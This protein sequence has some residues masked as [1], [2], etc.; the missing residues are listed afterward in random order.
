MENADN[1]L[2]LS[3]MIIMIQNDPLYR[4]LESAKSWGADYLSG[5]TPY[6]FDKKTADRIIDDLAKL[7]CALSSKG[8][9]KPPIPTEAIYPALTII[10]REVNDIYENAVKKIG[11]SSR[12]I[13][14]EAKWK[15][16][17]LK[18]FDE[19]S[20]R[21]EAIQREYLDDDD[22]YKLNSGK[23]KR[24]FFC[25]LYESC[26]KPLFKNYPFSIRSRSIYKAF[27]EYKKKQTDQ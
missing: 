27:R 12:L 14:A 24:D 19:N 22:L 7:V 6:N 16:A 11:F 1:E 2:S 10:D 23:E 15:N 13:D 3:E 25:R 4:I 18:Y 20:E 21:F 8:K 26:L 9:H 17:A 5:S